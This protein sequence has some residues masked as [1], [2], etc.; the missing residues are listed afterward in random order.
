M[1]YSRLAAVG[2]QIRW[3]LKGG[4]RRRQS[5]RVLAISNP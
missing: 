3:R 5:L 1:Q 2:P 4:R